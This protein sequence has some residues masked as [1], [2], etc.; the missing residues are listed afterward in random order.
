MLGGVVQRYDPVIGWSPVCADGGQWTAADGN[1]VC[2]ELGLSGSTPAAGTVSAASTTLQTP[3]ASYNCTGGEAFLGSCPRGTG[4]TRVIQGYCV[5]NNSPHVNLGHYGASNGGVQA[6]AAAAQN[7][8]F[9][10]YIASN[11]RCRGFQ[12]TCTQPHDCSNDNS[13]ACRGGAVIYQTGTAGC[14]SFATAACVAPNNIRL[15]GGG[16]ASA[17]RVEVQY[18][19]QWGTVCDDFWGQADAEV[20][21]RSLGYPGAAP[22]GAVSRAFFGQGTGP[23]LLDNVQCPATGA[24]PNLFM[25]AHNNVTVHNCAH[26]EDAGVVCNPMTRILSAGPSTTGMSGLLEVYSASAGGWQVVS[27]ADAH[28]AQIACAELG[29]GGGTVASGA[30]VPNAPACA[31][32]V[33]CSA[34]GGATSVLACSNTAGCPTVNTLTC[35]QPVATPAPTPHAGNGSI[36]LV[37]GATTATSVSGRLE[38]YVILNGT[39]VWGTVCDDYFGATVA[40][41]ACRQ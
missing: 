40:T 41:V 5:G 19:G 25:C 18:R 12:G 22:N 33:T 35:T 36:R 4:Y 14:T 1:V 9:F 39:G 37:G 30:A 16:N 26:S 2:R 10:Q 6:C 3:G 28:T 7:Y 32:T 11:G 24:P 21:C 27:V 13:A 8:N 31:S 23:I 34:S 17:G 15:R 29:Y 38:I 20:A